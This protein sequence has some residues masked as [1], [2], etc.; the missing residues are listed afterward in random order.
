MCT[1]I[2]Y[3]IRCDILKLYIQD[4]NN[5]WRY[6]KKSKYFESC[7][8]IYSQSFHNN[9]SVDQIPVSNLARTTCLWN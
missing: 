1:L 3:M 5:K 8:R 7:A 6:K 2:V 9:K 4:K